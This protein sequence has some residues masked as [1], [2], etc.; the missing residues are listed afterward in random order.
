[1]TINDFR[2]EYRFLSNFHI[3]DVL[4]G[5]CCFHSGEAAYQADK[6]F[7]MEEKRIIWLA[8]TP[9]EAR[10]LGQKVTIRPDWDQVK[11]DVMLNVVRAKFANREL[12]KKLMDTGDAELIEGNWW[13]DNFFGSCSCEKCGNKGQN[14]LGKILMI[15]RQELRDGKIEIPWADFNVAQSDIVR[16]DGEVLGE[17]EPTK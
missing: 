17:L 16:S 15:V 7:V 3:G 1:M 14:N 12:S 6:T 9:K 8:A 13:H 5:G 10:R 2:G 11:Y 4:Y